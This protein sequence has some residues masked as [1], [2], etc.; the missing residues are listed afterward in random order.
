MVAQTKGLT[1]EQKELFE[2]DGFLAYSENK[3]PYRRRAIAMSYMSAR[4]KDPEHSERRYPVLRG[5]EHPGCV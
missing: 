1:A 3:T 2:R 4:S 5:Q